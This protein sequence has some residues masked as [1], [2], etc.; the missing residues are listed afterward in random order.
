ML[1][2]GWHGPSPYVLLEYHPL[3]SLDQYLRSHKL[4]WS[5]CYSFLVTLLEAIDYLHYENLSPND[6]FTASRIR[7]P[8]MIHR[9]IKT[10]N[11]VVQSSS[12]P[13]LCLID[14]GLGKVLPSILACHDFIQV[15]TYRYMAPELLE[16]AITHTSEA[17]CKVD[18]YAV[19]L[20]MWEII[21]Q[22][23]DY[24]CERI[25]STGI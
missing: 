23:L 2:Y 8:I 20:V 4:S 7:K 16:L 9:D 25:E 5:T 6:Y 17:L 3:G 22:C 11:I 12:Q 18:M 15:G 14:F 10:S 19:G 21:T 24:P 13:S 1:S